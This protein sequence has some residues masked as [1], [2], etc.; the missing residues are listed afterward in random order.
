MND[1]S[2]YV[3]RGII[4]KYFKRLSILITQIP[5]EVRRFLLPP[6]M[7]YSGFKGYLHIGP[8][9]RLG[10]QIYR[11][12]ASRFSI[13]TRKT[14]NRVEQEIFGVLGQENMFRINGRNTELRGG[15]L[16]C[17]DFVEK[18]SHELPKG[19]TI[20]TFSKPGVTG[21]VEIGKE[22]EVKI[23]NCSIYWIVG[24]K[25]CVKHIPFAWLFGNASYLNEIDPFLHSESDFYSSLFGRLYEIITRGY[26]EPVDRK[27][28]LK[29]REIYVKL[30]E[31]VENELKKQL[32]ATQ[33]D[34]YVFQQLLIK[35]KFFLHPG[36]MLIESQP[37]LR[38][39]VLRK[40]DFH[41]EVSENE[42]IYVEIEPPFFKPFEDSNL[43]RRLR[44][45]LKQVSEWKEILIQQVAGKEN[46]S[47]LI[48]IGLLDDLN[49]EEKDTLQAFNKAQEDVAVV[50]WDWVLENID[51]IKRE[52]MSKLA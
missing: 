1:Q 52:M 20:L 22:A 43:S 38:G 30:I 4:R 40:P 10:F 21:P 26:E 16:T 25:R 12:R 34:E 6:Y 44:G 46:I 23:M 28:K 31:R 3:L 7:L 29:V 50:T 2:D 24:N 32:A 35:Y 17:K 15:I 9:G 41:V 13:K 47:Y 42:H 49:K 33:A 27:T 18:Y 5:F 37:Q 19:A 8:S 11:E 36:A 48:I 51:K 39:K 14:R 45:A